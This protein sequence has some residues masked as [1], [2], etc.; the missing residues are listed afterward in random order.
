MKALR[1]ICL[2][3]NRQKDPELRVTREAVRL[4]TDSGAE[5]FV[6]APLSE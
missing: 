2:M 5:V 3:P 6:L 4:L 1:R